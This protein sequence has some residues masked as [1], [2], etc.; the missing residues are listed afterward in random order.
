LRPLELAVEVSPL[1]AAPVAV[2]LHGF[3]VWAAIVLHRR[4]RR[5]SD[6]ETSR[7]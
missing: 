3:G 2:L 6:G 1:I 4:R 5:R 7:S